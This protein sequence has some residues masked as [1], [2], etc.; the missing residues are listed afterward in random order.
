MEDTLLLLED[1]G[2]REHLAADW[3]KNLR[4]FEH[5]SHDHRQAFSFTKAR[6]RLVHTRIKTFGEEFSPI[7][8]GLGP[9]QAATTPSTN[10]LLQA[11]HSPNPTRGRQP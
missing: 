11:L 8:R 4:I 2:W 6:K 7:F 9:N 5:S 10:T 3:L 1:R